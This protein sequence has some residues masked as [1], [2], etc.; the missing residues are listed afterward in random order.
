MHE[1]KRVQLHTSS[2]TE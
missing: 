2:Y 1:Y